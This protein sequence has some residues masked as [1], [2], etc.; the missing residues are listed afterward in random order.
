MSISD[1]ELN[2]RNLSIDRYRI[3][4]AQVRGEWKDVSNIEITIEDVQTGSETTV[5]ALKYGW[6]YKHITS[7]E[8]NSISLKNLDSII[9]GVSVDGIIIAFGKRN[10]ERFESTVEL[11]RAEI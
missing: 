5:H 2:S 8:E 7:I 9:Y 1:Q 10:Q 11:L 4:Q 6:L 3:K